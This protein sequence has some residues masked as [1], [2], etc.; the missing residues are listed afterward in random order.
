MGNNTIDTAYEQMANEKRKA[1]EN[2]ANDFA[3]SA[4]RWANENYMYFKSEAW[5]DAYKNEIGTSLASK[6]ALPKLS[7]GID[8]LGNYKGE[9]DALTELY[10]GRLAEIQTQRM[11]PGR[12]QN[13]Y[14][15]PSLLG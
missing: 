8:I 7:V 13:S 2:W 15:T 5:L 9:I 12:E 10:R 14:S 4:E 11:S 6:G 1:S 3:R